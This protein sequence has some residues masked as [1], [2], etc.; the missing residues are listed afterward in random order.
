MSCSLKCKGWDTMIYCKICNEEFDSEVS[1]HKHFRGAH[2]M[3]YKQY[4]PKYEPKYDLYDGSLLPFKNREHYYATDFTKKRNLGLWLDKKASP[5]KGREYLLK[6]LK[7]RKEKKGLKYAPC[8]VTLRTTMIP[9][10]G[11]FE[12][13]FDSYD[14]AA[15]QAGLEPRFKAKRIKLRPIDENFVI[16][17]DTREQKPLEFNHKTVRMKCDIGD[18]TALSDYHANLFIDRKNPNDFV[19]TFSAGFER[20]EAEVKRA[21]SLNSYIVV[22]VEWPLNKMMG[23]NYTYLNRFTKVNPEYVFNHVR[24]L[25]ENYD[26]IQFLFVNDRDDASLC[27]EKIFRM[28]ETAKDVDLQLL[29]DKKLLCG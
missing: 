16:A 2:K 29:Y 24:R 7:D 1:F 19:G 4:Y 3:S 10:I 20:F 23:F 25:L 21:V 22:L 9:A 8:Q 17:V 15:T 14:D 27:A 26:N 12:K 18:Y 28:G 11:Y 5:E 6:L 13:F